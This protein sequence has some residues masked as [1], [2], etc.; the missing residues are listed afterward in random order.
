MP[1]TEQFTCKHQLW[2]QE[3]A[4]RSISPYHNQSYVFSRMPFI[5]HSESLQPCYQARDCKTPTTFT[6]TITFTGLSEGMHLLPMSARLRANHPHITHPL[7]SFLLLNVS[8]GTLRPTTCP[9]FEIHEKRYSSTGTPGLPPREG[10]A[11]KSSFIHSLVP[12]GCN[13]Y[14]GLFKYGCSYNWGH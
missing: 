7:Q 3:K 6:F 8:K 12:Q 11:R 2:L 10:S 14:H 1:L 13:L 4:L 9:T 5:W